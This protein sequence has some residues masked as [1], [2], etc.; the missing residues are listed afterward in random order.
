M[1]A[2]LSV[3]VLEIV[4]LAVF[5]EAA[6]ELMKP[7]VSR[8]DW[9]LGGFEVPYALSLLFGL[10]L[11]AVMKVNLFLWASMTGVVPELMSGLLIGRVSNYI[12]NL[13]GKKKTSLRDVISEDESGEIVV[14]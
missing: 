14:E 5:I 7:I 6:V 11:G 10:V 12:F 8:I 2:G 3:G 4:L 13:L 1:G 9:S